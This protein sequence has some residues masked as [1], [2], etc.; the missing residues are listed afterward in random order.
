[1]TQRT[2]NLL[3]LGAIFGIFI[4]FAIAGR[5]FVD[6]A[7]MDRLNRG[8]L[9][10][11]HVPIAELELTT[12]KGQA[13]TGEDMAG[14][15]SLMYIAGN[16]CKQACKNALFYLMTR[17]RRSL[18]QDADR[19]RLILVHTRPPSDQLRAFMEEKLAPMV[20]LQGQPGPIRKALASAFEGDIDPRHHLYMV[21]P[22]GQIF[23]WYPPH[24]DK[25]AL[26]EEADGI[27]EDLTRTLKGART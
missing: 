11:P 27:Y 26:L 4:A 2:R 21:A 5:Y 25:E 23:M 12:T 10:V 17:L 20:E 24:K 6:P 8:T 18:A 13:W 7:E 14:Q 22:D 16:Q 19:L 1:M 3:V 9:I 15:W